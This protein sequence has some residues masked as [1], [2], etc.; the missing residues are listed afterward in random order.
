MGHPGNCSFQQ[1]TSVTQL[2]SLKSENMAFIQFV[3][4]TCG[5]VRGSLANLGKFSL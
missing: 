5:L 2:C 4:L 1:K 3:S